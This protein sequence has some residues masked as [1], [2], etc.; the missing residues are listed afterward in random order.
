MA[1]FLGHHADKESS[2][3]TW[4]SPLRPAESFERYA[5]TYTRQI[6]IRDGRMLAMTLTKK[7]GG[8][9]DFN[10]DGD[11]VTSMVRHNNSQFTPGHAIVI[12]RLVSV[13]TLIYCE[14]ISSIC[15]STL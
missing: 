11:V 6:I 2:A 13:A 12:E 9:R 10:L 5:G 4:S 15:A 8:L 1:V 7:C 14:R 3:K